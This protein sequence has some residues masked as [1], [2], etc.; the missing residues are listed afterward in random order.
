[1]DIM[2]FSPMR[3][4]Q[5]G[6][7][8]VKEWNYSESEISSAFWRAWINDR[9]NG[10]LLYNGRRIIMQ[11]HTIYLIAPETNIST[12]STG[13]FMQLYIHFS[14]K[15]P[16]HEPQDNVFTIPAWPE[17]ER[18]MGQF[19]EKFRNS[20]Q[21]FL[22]V[23]GV[24][25]TA[26]SKLPEKYFIRE[27][28]LDKRIIS[29]LKAVSGTTLG[30]YTNKDLAARVH[31]GESAFIHLFTR[32]L[33]VSPQVYYRNKRIERAKF[34]L[35]FTESSIES[36]AADTGF[37]DRYHFSRIFRTLTGTTPARYRKQHSGG[38]AVD[39]GE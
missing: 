17:V 27:G 7:S 16:G 15:F 25:H 31:M 37:V 9:E 5:W 11:E 39:P 26:V 13:E 30:H 12:E 21:A 28:E 22:S 36:I 14:M 19:K 2:N 6:F 1:M 4:H 3:I 10:V 33:G 23:S 32:Q 34:L 8:R 24:L 38:K 35:A 29:T 18:L 20:L